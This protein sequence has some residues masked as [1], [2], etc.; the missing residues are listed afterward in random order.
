MFLE[1]LKC[2]NCEKEIKKTDTVYIK[3]KAKELS[4][5]A[6]LKSWAKDKKVICKD[7]LEKND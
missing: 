1:K 2:S 3:V 4:G 6:Y 7:C 5:Y